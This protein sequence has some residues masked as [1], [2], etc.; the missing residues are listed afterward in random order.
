MAKAGARVGWGRPRSYPA[1]SRLG[2]SWLGDRFLAAR[3][4]VCAIS[5]RF[6]NCSDAADTRPQHPPGPRPAAPLGTPGDGDGGTEGR[7]NREHNTPTH[8]RTP[9][10][11]PNPITE[12]AR[13]ALVVLP[14]GERSGRGGAARCR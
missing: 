10:G 8:P 1:P 11:L 5:C 14:R 12:E 13:G 9:L 7:N 6:V 3:G 4:I 2:C